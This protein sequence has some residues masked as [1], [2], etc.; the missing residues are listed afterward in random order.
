[1]QGS[2]ER[3]SREAIC[4]VLEQGKLSFAVFVQ[5][6]KTG[7]HPDMTEELL[8]G[9]YVEHQHMINAIS[10]KQFGSRSGRKYHRN[11]NL[12]PNCLHMVIDTTK[13]GL[14]RKLI[15]A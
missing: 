10:F 4:Y 11:V 6:R 7:K 3:D 9:I 13:A 5:P 14:L 15:L 8:T 12:G 2:L 1:M